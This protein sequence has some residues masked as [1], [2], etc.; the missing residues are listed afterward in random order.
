ML[1][2]VAS[3]YAPAYDRLRSF[4]LEVG[5]LKF[6]RPLYHAMIQGDST[7]DLARE[8]YELARVRYHPIATHA[9]DDI[10]SQD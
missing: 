9:L 3:E 8:V 4:L 2:A 5:R 6:I 1:I 7:R 10:L